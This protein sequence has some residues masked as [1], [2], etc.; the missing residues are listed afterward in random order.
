MSPPSYARCPQCQEA[1]CDT[2]ITAPYIRGLVLAAT[3][4]SKKFVGCRRCVQKQLLGEVGISAVAGWFSLTALMV[5][6]I[7]IVY[8]GLRI[9]FVKANPEKVSQ[10][11]EE[12]GI[13]GV[14][15]N[16]AR[17]AAALAAS[18]VAADGVTEPAEVE[19]AILLGSHLF[20]EFT[21]DLF[22]KVL[23]GVED[24][25]ATSELAWML[26]DTLPQEGKIMI[27]KYLI[28]I[29]DSDGHIDASEIHE[30]QTVLATLGVSMQELKGPRMSVPDPGA[31]SSS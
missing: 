16:L 12:V 1:K 7:C 5:N 3:Y 13:D 17:V 25:P 4:G 30:L 9:P 15:V 27:A 29:A 20:E 23:D 24:L 2:V 6:P 26:A 10:L 21:P 14:D 11:L 22:R 19:T 18:M 8:N 31:S 28:A